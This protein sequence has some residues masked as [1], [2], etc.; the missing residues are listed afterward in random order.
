MQAQMAPVEGRAG[1]VV[2]YERSVLSDK[3]IFG[4]SPPTKPR[5]IARLC[6]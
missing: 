6:A 2:V 5:S 3:H 1:Q 4:R